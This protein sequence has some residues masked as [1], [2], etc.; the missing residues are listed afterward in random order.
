MLLVLAGSSCCLLAS[1][2]CCLCL[3][4]LLLLSTLLRHLLELAVGAVAVPPVELAAGRCCSK[5]LSLLL[6]CAVPPVELAAGAVAAATV[7]SFPH[8]LL[9]LL[10]RRLLG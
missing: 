3:L 10:R 7:V 2:A 9:Q 1:S 8:L 4:L 6:R 5:L